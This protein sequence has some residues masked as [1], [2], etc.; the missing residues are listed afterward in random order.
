LVNQPARPPNI[1]IIPS[2]T[3]GHP[4]DIGIIVLTTPS[5][6]MANVADRLGH[7]V[8]ADIVE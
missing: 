2:E 7:F 3:Y 1:H 5:P 4:D 8:V 6:K